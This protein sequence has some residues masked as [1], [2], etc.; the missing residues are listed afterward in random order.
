[1]F[2]LKSEIPA[3]TKIFIFREIENDSD[4]PDGRRVS[5]ALADGFDQ[6]QQLKILYLAQWYNLQKLLRVKLNR[7]GLNQI[8]RCKR[9][10]IYGARPIATTNWCDYFSVR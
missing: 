6:S 4:G 2:A 10:R 1:M 5:A 3:V 7:F 8:T 9:D